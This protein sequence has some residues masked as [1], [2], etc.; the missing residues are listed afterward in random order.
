MNYCTN[1]LIQIYNYFLRLSTEKE[2]FL[3]FFEKATKSPRFCSV[4]HRL[5]RN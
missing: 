1:S 5:A 2:N 3:I 4:I